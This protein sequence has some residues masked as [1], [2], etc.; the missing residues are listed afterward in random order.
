MSANATT[1]MHGQSSNVGPL[2]AAAVLTAV[3]AFGALGFAIGQGVATTTTTAARPVAGPVID[4]TSMSGPRSAAQKGLSPAA[5][6][7]VQFAADAYIVGTGWVPDRRH[8]RRRRRFAPST[9]GG[10]PSRRPPGTA[11]RSPPQGRR[12]VDR[13][14]ERQL[15]GTDSRPS[16]RTWLKAQ[17]MAIGSDFPDLY[18]RSHAPRAIAR[19]AAPTSRV[20][21]RTGSRSRP[22]RQTPRSRTTSSAADHTSRTRSSVRHDAYERLAGRLRGSVR[23]WVKAQAAARLV[24]PGLLPASHS[25]RRRGSGGRRVRSRSDRI[26]CRRHPTATSQT[27]PRSPGRCLVTSVACDNPAMGSDDR[28]D[29]LIGSLAG[30]HRTWLVYLGVELGLFE[31]LRSAGEAG[32]TA[33]ALADGRATASSRPSTPGCGPPTPTS[34]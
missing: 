13:A 10:S 16:T 32:L 30:F 12:C 15:S 17:T 21:T 1:A 27:P 3:V 24:L 4:N 31:R 11:P 23:P 25:S 28:F 7:R 33:E 18:Q 34:S 19:T 22:R 14:P 20:S 9:S 26:R 2:G 8:G 29:D 6:P 5:N